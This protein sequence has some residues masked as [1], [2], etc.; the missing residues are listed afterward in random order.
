MVLPSLQ[1]GARGPG[2]LGCEPQGSTATRWGCGPSVRWRR[3][4]TPSS[5]AGPGGRGLKSVPGD[6]L[7]RD[8]DVISP[9][10][11]VYLPPLFPETSEVAEEWGGRRVDSEKAWEPELGGCGLQLGRGVRTRRKGPLGPRGLVWGR[12][13]L[14]GEARVPSLPSGAWG[15]LPGGTPTQQLPTSRTKGLGSTARVRERRWREAGRPAVGAGRAPPH[16]SS[17]GRRTES[18]LQS[19]PQ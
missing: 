10:P 2:G 7:R 9:P 4:E 17:R 1:L 14:G 18:S 16:I 11:R 15:P 19:T 6:S 13:G 12:L 8:G 3:R 5:A